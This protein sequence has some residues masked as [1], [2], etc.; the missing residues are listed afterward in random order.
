METKKASSALIPIEEA[1]L[2][3][4]NRREARSFLT[5]VLSPAEFERLRKRWQVYQLRSNGMPLA[6]I[7]R[8]ARVAMATASRGAALHH[9]RHRQILNALVSRVQVRNGSEQH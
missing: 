2:A 6:N 3:L 7:V 1:I 9:S 4:E 8:T 5:A